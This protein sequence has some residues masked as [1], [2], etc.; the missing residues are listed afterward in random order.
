MH[1]VVQKPQLNIGCVTMIRKIMYKQAE[2]TVFDENYD[3]FLQGKRKQCVL[4]AP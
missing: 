2:L 1:E 3:C 4:Y